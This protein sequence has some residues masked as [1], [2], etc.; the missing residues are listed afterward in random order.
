MRKNMFNKI[1]RTV[2]CLVMAGSMFI[3]TGQYVPAAEE[4]G[5][6]ASL[7]IN[8]GSAEE[9]L[10][11]EDS[12]DGTDYVPDNAVIPGEEAEPVQTA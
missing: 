6:D 5:T 7:V 2:L 8:E 11:P 9:S 10:F 3:C 12:T 4:S 1:R